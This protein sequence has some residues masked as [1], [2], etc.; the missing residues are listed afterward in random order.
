M[1]VR[2]VLMA[3]AVAAGL[4]VASV[5]MADTF[6]TT[7]D[8]G[9]ETVASP[10]LMVINFGLAGRFSGTIATA[11]FNPLANG[12]VSTTGLSAAGSSTFQTF[13]MEE[14]PP[15]YFWPGKQVQ[16]V[17]SNTNTVNTDGTITIPGSHA[18]KGGGYN[19][20]IPAVNAYGYNLSQ[21]AAWLYYQFATGQLAGY[22]YVGG[23]TTVA[24]QNAFWY[25]TNNGVAPNSWSAL[26]AT[27]F[28]GYG[29]PSTSGA[30][31]NG[32]GQQLDFVEVT[33]S[34]SVKT[35]T[36]YSVHVLNTWNPGVWT[37]T[38]DGGGG[39]ILDETKLNL[40]S[41]TSPVAS[42]LIIPGGIN[43]GLWSGPDTTSLTDERVFY[44]QD[45][46]IMESSSKSEPVPLPATVWS[47]GALL[48]LV[49]LGRM[50]KSLNGN[51]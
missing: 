39:F 49:V 48:G 7:A 38:P 1:K 9:T 30:L 25:L 3:A 21:G 16:A 47:A 6:L 14:R 11:K 35:T 44:R 17:I 29:T 50:R 34:G 36:T 32:D 12:Y 37:A 22:D 19:G 10:D 18:I 4:G 43:D 15:E 5:A 2:N 28:G 27:Q 24:L 8:G 31:F 40:Q 46:L 20:G 51:A 23:T 41:A 42:T 33:I 26:A 13:C 45:Q